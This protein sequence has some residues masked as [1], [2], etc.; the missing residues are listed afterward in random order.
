MTIGSRNRCGS[1]IVIVRRKV[2]GS[3]G[4]GVW[5]LEHGQAR[6]AKEG[7]VEAVELR[8]GQ[9]LRTTTQQHSCVREQNSKQADAACPRIE[10]D[11]LVV[12]LC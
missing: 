5:H 8:Q 7:L 4:M 10:G 12:E 2:V 1:V 6:G 11:K 9:G 3:G